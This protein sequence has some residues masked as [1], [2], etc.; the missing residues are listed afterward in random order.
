MTAEAAVPSTE[1]A[2]AA[3]TVISALSAAEAG[4]SA[5]A[6]GPEPTARRA[7]DARYR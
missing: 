2:E 1:S 3:L 7:A 6:M 5:A 4:E